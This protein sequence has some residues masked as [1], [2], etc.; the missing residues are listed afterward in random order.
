MNVALQLLQASVSRRQARAA[1][2]R[3]S[4]IKAEELNRDVE[5]ISNQTAAIDQKESRWDFAKAVFLGEE[6][7]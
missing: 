1:G 3:A 4:A 7:A 5:A 6:E 2:R